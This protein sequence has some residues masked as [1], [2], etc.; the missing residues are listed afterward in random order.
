M[1]KVTRVG[2]ILLMIGVSFLLVTVLRGSKPYGPFGMEIDNLPANGW[3]TPN[4]F[5]WFP[6]E[7]RIEINANSP[8]DVYILDEK[9]R[10]IWTTNEIIDSTSSFLNVTQE[11][12]VLQINNRGS[13]AVLI[14]NP[15]AVNTSVSISM[16]LYGY[17]KDMLWASIFLISLGL[18][19]LLLSI[20]FGIKYNY[21]KKGT[22]SIKNNY[23]FGRRVN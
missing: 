11:M 16:T 23:Y 1:M 10:N 18:L 15:F 9:Q 2:I 13:Y 12:S 8:V 7:L 6:R 4:E 5:L 3:S 19:T 22:F 17:E 20:M 14:Y 21:H